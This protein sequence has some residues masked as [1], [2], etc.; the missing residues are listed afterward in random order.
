[1]WQSR[2]ARPSLPILLSTQPEQTY[3]KFDVKC[4]GGNQPRGKITAVFRGMMAVGA[5]SRKSS[6]A[7]V[8][9]SPSRGETDESGNLAR[10][11]GQGPAPLKRSDRP[12][13]CRAPS[14]PHPSSSSQQLFLWGVRTQQYQGSGHHVGIRLAEMRALQSNRAGANIRNDVRHSR[15]KQRPR[16]HLPTPKTTHSTKSGPL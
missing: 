7:G 8:F 15:R 9:P 13:A 4:A 5:A 3:A 16:G 1:V 10:K 6:L 14:E 2:G 11:V 12:T